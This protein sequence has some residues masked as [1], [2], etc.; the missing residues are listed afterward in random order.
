MYVLLKL[1]DERKVLLMEIRRPDYKSISTLVVVHKHHKTFESVHKKLVWRII[2]SLIENRGSWNRE[3][4]NSDEK[5]NFS[6]MKH[7]KIVSISWAKRI[8]IKIQ[9]LCG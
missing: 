2:H 8:S 3:Q 6:F 7:T 5:Y 1:D 4:L 9:Q